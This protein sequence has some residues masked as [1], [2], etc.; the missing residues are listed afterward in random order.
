VSSGITVGDIQVPDNAIQNADMW[1]WQRGLNVDRV[2]N[3]TGLN[4]YGPD[5]FRLTTSGTWNLKIRNVDDQDLT[6]S[7]YP[8]NNRICRITAVGAHSTL[9]ATDQ[10]YLRYGME[11]YDFA[12]IDG[13]PWTYTMW[14]RTNRVG[15]MYMGVRMIVVHYDASQEYF[16][17]DFLINPN[18]TT[19]LQLFYPARTSNLGYKNTEGALL[20]YVT[21][22]GGTNVQ[23]TAS[24]AWASGAGTLTT[25]R[26]TNFFDAANNYVDIWGPCLRTG[27]IVAPTRVNPDGA[28]SLSRLQRYFAKSY[29]ADI[30]PGAVTWNGS[31]TIRATTTTDT[32]GKVSFPVPMRIS[33]PVITVY[34]TSGTINTIRD[35]VAGADRT[36]AGV[37]IANINEFGFNEIG[38]TGATAGNEHG[39]HYTAE[40]DF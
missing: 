24:S 31:E 27:S 26:Q 17:Q 40:A 18:G 6:F 13:L 8:R 32:R 9:L 1:Y 23:G 4:I 7:G 34:S 30:N 10:A 20:V 16:T 5:R 2:I 38:V 39:F 15:T 11:G 25:T 21:F 29:G 36:V 19:A 35:I 14:V 3:G 28:D 12:R 22:A 33:S 37:G